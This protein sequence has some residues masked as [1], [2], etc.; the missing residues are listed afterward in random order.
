MHAQSPET[1]ADLVNVVQ[2]LSLARSAEA[3]VD[4]VRRAARRLTGADGA[5]VVLR[6]GDQCH[7]V[8]EDA[9]GPLWKGQ[10]F[11]MTSCVSGWVMMNRQPAVIPDI[12]DDP[13]V[14]VNTYTPTF[15]RSLVIV[16]IREADPLGAIGNYWSRA[17]QP[18]SGEVR[19]LQTLADTT[20]VALENARV[21]RE[22]EGRVAARTADLT[23]ANAGLRDA[24][25]RVR[26]LEDFDRLE[27]NGEWLSI[28]E[29]LRRRSGPRVSHGMSQEAFEVQMAEAL[30]EGAR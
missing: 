26:T 4:I 27:L 5:S 6:D 14:P 9:V 2:E 13:R 11:P 8:D 18:V 12:F 20:A 1:V 25:D 10:R 15:V 7:Y 29:Y 16:P 23:R 22:L 17:R 21:Y 19:L 30:S 3:V 24:L 28:T